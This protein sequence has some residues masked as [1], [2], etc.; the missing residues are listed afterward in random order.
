M[1]SKVV[2]DSG[3]INL[4]YSDC[5]QCEAV[6][7]DGISARD[8]M[9]VN[10]VTERRI[11]LAETD[12]VKEYFRRVECLGLSGATFFPIW[13]GIEEQTMTSPQKI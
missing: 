2:I 10:R 4:S 12:R 3:I 7:K 8:G 9:S 5:L 11:H 1:Q 6:S 13:S